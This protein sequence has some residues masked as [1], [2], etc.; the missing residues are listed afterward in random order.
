MVKLL[1][2]M[3]YIEGK[4]KE[5]LLANITRVTQENGEP[6]TFQSLDYNWS[7]RLSSS[8]KRFFPPSFCCTRM[9]D[10]RLDSAKVHV[11]PIQW[12]IR[13][14]GHDLLVGGL[15]AAWAVIF[16]QRHRR[17]SENPSLAQIFNQPWLNQ[18][19]IHSYALFSHSFTPL[20]IIWLIVA[21]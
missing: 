5:Y 4:D 13:F 11:A 3:I 10:G 12:N 20:P 19:Y 8:N 21:H 9:A 7:R 1:K 18:W 14:V 6:R 2:E 15:F 17:L 16:E